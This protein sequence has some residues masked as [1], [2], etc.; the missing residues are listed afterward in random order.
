MDQWSDILSLVEKLGFTTVYQCRYA[1]D[2]IFPAQIV[3]AHPTKYLLLVARSFILAD[4]EDL[5]DGFIY[6]TA[7]STTPLE[8]GWTLPFIGGGFKHGVSGLE[9]LVE[10]EI[11]LSTSPEFRL[12]EIG[13]KFQFVKWG[14]S[15]RFLSLNSLAQRKMPFEQSQ[16]ATEIFLASFPDW[17]KDFIYNS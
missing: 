17:V 14:S 11:D 16:Q 13:K 7:K 6:G 2:N 15:H 10:F 5:N 9:H 3:A 1:F 12:D 8:T 4:H